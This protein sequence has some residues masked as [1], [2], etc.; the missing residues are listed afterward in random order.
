[1]KIGTREQRFVLIS[2]SA[3]RRRIFKLI[4]VKLDG[5]SVII[6]RSIL[7]RM[8]RGSPPTFSGKPVSVRRVYVSHAGA[9]LAQLRLI[10][11]FKALG[12]VPAWRMSASLKRT[13]F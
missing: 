1:M 12:Y 13:S 9:R 3:I 4:H 6:T 10:A 7:E 11:S 5:R 2:G 8:F